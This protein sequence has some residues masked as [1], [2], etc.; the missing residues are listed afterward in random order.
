MAGDAG[1]PTENPRESG[2]RV[3]LLG[4]RIGTE[5]KTPGSEF[6]LGNVFSADAQYLG[7]DKFTRVY[8]K[9]ASGIAFRN[10]RLINR[11]TF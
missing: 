9:T 7:G 8:L 1:V 11:M 2:V 4:G 6:D 3:A 10:K 5:Y